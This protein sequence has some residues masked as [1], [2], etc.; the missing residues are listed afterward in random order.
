MSVARSVALCLGLGLA[1]S[2]PALAEG[3]GTAAEIPAA[4]PRGPA[5]T[6]EAC[7]AKA[8][9]RYP[10]SRQYALIEANRDIDV[11]VARRG[12][13]PRLALSGKAT[14]QSD[15]T[16]FDSIASSLPPQMASAFG[17]GGAGKD[18]YQAIAELSLTIWDG[19]AIP[20]QVKGIQSASR[21]ESRKLDVDLYALNDKVDQLFF[22]ILS[23]REQLEQDAILLDQ[24]ESSYRRVKASLD[25]GAASPYDLDA[26]RVEIL[27]ARQ[28]DAELAAGER[29][30]REMLSDM[31]G[32]SLPESSEFA[33]PEDLV[34]PE[35]DDLARRPEMAL[36]AAQER[37]LDSQ[38]SAIRAANMPR[39]SAF[40]QA[41][42]G[43]PGLDMFESGASAYWIGG[44]K[45]TWSLNGLLDW[46]AQLRKVDDARKTVAA[47]RDAFILNSG[48]QVA[49]SRNDVARLRELLKGDDEIIALRESMRMSTEG[50]QENGAATTDDVLKAID[51]ESLARRTKSLHEVQL[52]MA[53]YALKSALA[54]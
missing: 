1:L 16:S 23:L 26:V 21:V 47:Q 18:Q 40:L 53:A 3:R 46:K 15:V 5:L 20:A 38:E 29:S 11:G 54:K 30:Y 22:G 24:L 10:T 9:A 27:N 51:A 25:N 17:A 44:L 32:E 6:I 35:D 7:R 28:K 39:L 52:A 42:Y 37:Q 34:A 45:A 48:L 50:K 2:G 14:L 33:M 43:D 4:A 31:I 8:R 12:Y 13:L 41:A 19:G 49:R 36:F